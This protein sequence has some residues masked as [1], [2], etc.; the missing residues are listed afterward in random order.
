MTAPMSWPLYWAGGPFRVSL[1]HP[2]NMPQ[3]HV[4]RVITALEAF[5]SDCQSHYCAFSGSINGRTLAYE[6]FKPLMKSRTNMVSVGTGPP[7]SEQQPGES[8]IA[9]MHQ[10]DL[11]DGL[12]PGGTFE[13]RHAKAFIVMIYHRWDEYFRQSIA[14]SISVRPSRV[15]CDMMGDIRQ[16]RNVIIHDNSE[17]AQNTIGKLKLLPQIWH[18]SVGALSLSEGMLQSL[19]EQ[20]N[21]M[22]VRIVEESV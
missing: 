8:T 17:I 7:D 19:M 6:R 2:N 4:D 1:Q 15:Q 18:L 22:H 11:L 10:G 5:R 13:D 21:A 16:V 3:E 14:E 12:M 20:I 9:T